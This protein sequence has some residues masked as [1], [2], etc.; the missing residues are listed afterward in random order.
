MAW[1]ARLDARARKWPAAVRWAYLGFRW[2]LILLGVY[3]VIG[4]AFMEI[5]E[6]RVGLGTGVLVAVTFGVIKGV[7]MASR[8]QE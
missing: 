2:L 7:L 6:G 8:R 3:G 1:L 4:L 5:S